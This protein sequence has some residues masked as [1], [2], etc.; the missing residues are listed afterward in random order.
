MQTC[1]DI[2]L[3]FPHQLFEGIEPLR[4]KK[5]LLIEEPLFFTQYRFHIQKLV[6]HRASMKFYEAYLREQKITVEYY[7]DERYLQRYQD[8]TIYLYDVVDD[9]LSKKLH[10]HFRQ[11]RILPNPNFL[12]VQ[13]SN[14]FLHHYYINR[15]KEL[16]IFMDNGKPYGGKWSF[17]SDN[18][19]KLPK[20]IRIP[21]GLLFENSHIEEAKTYCQ[22]FD[23]VG[24]CEN[25]YYPTTFGEAKINFQH[26]LSA[27][28]AHF[29]DYQDAIDGR[30]PYLFHS[31]ISSSL[32]NG[33]LDLGYVI[34]QVLKQDVPYNAKE[35]FIRQII[36]W[37]E[38]MLTVYRSSH[39]PL[40]TTN[41]FG[42]SRKIPP[43]L[44]SGKSG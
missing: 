37:R 23:T 43:K 25:F 6:L 11:L 44:L 8:H 40:R 3:I 13:D 18:R 34:D 1:S 41:F 19:K 17:D 27:K 4:G 36:G 15:R 31:N 38:F 33:L 29:G 21:P 10:R 39:I 26:F 32:N 42:F 22:R 9:W 7:E 28:F 16:G 14:R 5:V 30:N 2:F 12:N 20:E 35:G 24:S